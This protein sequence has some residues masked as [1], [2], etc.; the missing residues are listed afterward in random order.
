MGHKHVIQYYELFIQGS[1]VIQNLAS[2][3][4]LLFQISPFLLM[5]LPML[6]KF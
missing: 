5:I 1:N 3:I 2:A 4:V 6:Q